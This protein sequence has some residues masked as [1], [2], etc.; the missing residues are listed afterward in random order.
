MWCSAAPAVTAVGC[1]DVEEEGVVFGSTLHLSKL[2]RIYVMV[3]LAGS[4]E[5]HTPTCFQPCTALQA[6]VASDNIFEHYIMG[7]EYKTHPLTASS[8]SIG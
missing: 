3:K 7:I 1:H 4:C 8:R 5:F 2:L 6:E